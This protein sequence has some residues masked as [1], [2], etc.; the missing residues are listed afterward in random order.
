M[1]MMNPALDPTSLHAAARIDALGDE[2]EAAWDAGAHPRIEDFLTNLP[3]TDHALGLVALLRV[4]LELRQRLGEHPELAEYQARFPAQREALA[5]L[6]AELAHNTPIDTSV[7]Q[8]QSGTLPNAPQAVTPPNR[9]L[10]PA[11]IGRFAI[12][13][14]LGEGAFGTVYRARD[15]QLDREV[16]IKVPRAGA[17][18]Q[19]ADVER[20]LRE[21]KV[22]ATMHHPNICPVYEVG[23][24]NGRPYIVMALVPGKS[25]ADHLKQRTQPFPP[26]QAALILRKLALALD[27]AHHK[28]IV[29]RDLKPANILIDEDRRDVVV[30]DFGLAHR[31][32]RD[33]EQLTLS[34]MLL[35]TP[36]YMPPEQ[37]RGD[38]AAIGPASDIY[39]LGVILY[40]MLAGRRPYTG[41]VG[42][43]LGKI[44][45][46]DPPPPSAAREEVD[47]RLE[48]ICL[49][50]MAR[51]P[52]DRYASMRALAEAL[53]AWLRTTSGGDSAELPVVASPSVAE[54]ADAAQEA[55]ERA[56][57][58]P[59]SSTLSTRWPL[60]LAGLVPLS[61]F[62]AVAVVLLLPTAKGTVRVEINDP[63][64]KVVVDQG[65][66]TLQGA[67]KEHSIKLQPGEHGLT[68]TRGDFTFDTT[69]FELKKRGETTL[70]VEL[71]AG[72][73]QISQDG[74][75]LRSAALPAA[76]PQA[77][78]RGDERPTNVAP[79][80]ESAPSPMESAP[81][82]ESSGALA[83][84]GQDDY[85][86]LPSIPH[87]IDAPLTFEAWITPAISQG[88][89]ADD[90][91]FAVWGIH[92]TSLEVAP[93]GWRWK[94]Y[95]RQAFA[96]EASAGRRA[97]LVAQWDGK[98]C[99]IFV[100]GIAAT[101]GADQ[102]AGQPLPYRITRYAPILPRLLG[103]V[104][105]QRGEGRSGF[106]PGQ[107]HEVRISSAA[108][109]KANFTPPPPTAPFSADEQTIALYHLD[110]GQGKVLADVSGNEHHGQIVGAQ[111]I[112]ATSSL[113]KPT[114]GRPRSAP[115]SPHR[116]AAEWV[117][118]MHGQVAI[119]PSGGVKEQIKAV[120][121]LP[122]GP[123]E[124]VGLYLQY[125]NVPFDA[126]G[127]ASLNGLASLQSFGI[128]HDGLTDEAF[129]RLKDLPHVKDINIH[130]IRVTDIALEHVAT[131]PS[132]RGLNFGRTA[133][134]GKTL[135]KLK[136]LDLELLILNDGPIADEA[137][138]H[139][140]L[141]PHLH[142]LALGKT[143]ITDAGLAPLAEL[144][145]LDFL[146]LGETQ[147]TGAGLGALVS[148]PELKR[149]RLVNAAHVGKEATPHLE[150]MKRLTYL[151]LR[152]TRISPAGLTR[153]KQSLPQCE[154]DPP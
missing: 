134:T 7:A 154:I 39:S 97:H 148:L 11:Q 83:F 99:Q 30:M 43:V 112:D 17:L 100:N 16:A 131:F 13:G 21:S 1:A 5:A 121:K 34:G 128:E 140:P 102:E 114:A 87:K 67:D 147:I 80:P 88:G 115:P 38:T 146:D 64:I 96:G 3:E 31:E 124:L 143:A 86:L 46:V 144:K 62:V 142:H 104:G 110:E 150:Q 65:K 44:L 26:R 15:P 36:A 130:S 63:Q 139:L 19:P 137:L 68:V 105:D 66:V 23:A 133:V 77:V 92:H 76:P 14:K 27:L 25:L 72:A 132:V 9:E 50:A 107:L 58:R 61:L 56:A 54:N 71:L 42:E 153:L 111:W 69:N 129:C 116:A 47:A 123:F 94:H 119:V 90:A 41:S 81:P 152:G 57:A 48:A 53:T 45:H 85:V 75:V 101:K 89:L 127:I 40:E 73:L 117:L 55:D 29:H 49:K 60:W 151:E 108:R 98:T 35:G 84:D 32:D 120:V 6:F 113:T 28:G 74:R 2:F 125:P 122:A 37:A 24:E 22:A 70:K 10:D 78:V 51:R 8:T 135:D 59:P 33:A 18:T 82:P 103:A 20:F 126:K 12:C 141:F 106:F 95:G 149:L 145:Q 4:E 136:A 52:E 109:Y 138:R 79:P 91:S 118:G 93:V